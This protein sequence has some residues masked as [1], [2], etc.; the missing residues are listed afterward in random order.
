MHFEL[1]KEAIEFH[2]QHYLPF[3]ACGVE[4]HTAC[5]Y[6]D[7][8]IDMPW[9]ALLLEVDEDQ[10]FNYPPECDVQRDLNI[11]ASVA[12]GSGTKVVMLRYNADN[13]CMNNDV[14]RLPKRT[15]L[16]KLIAT[17]RQYQEE[18]PAPGLMFARRFLFYDLLNGELEVA[19]HWPQAVREISEVVV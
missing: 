3:K 17:I 10:H 18:E 11:A 2:Y 5:C 14:Q 8:S 9:G 7:F 12:L 13:F 16:K 1:E 15:R 4:G 19:Q 6:I